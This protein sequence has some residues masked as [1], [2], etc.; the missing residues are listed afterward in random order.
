MSKLNVIP[1]PSYTFG[2][3]IECFGGP[4]LHPAVIAYELRQ[5]GF[6]VRDQYRDE[7]DYGDDRDEDEDDDY[8][9]ERNGDDEDEQIEAAPPPA[10]N[11]GYDS[12]TWIIGGDG[13]IRGQNTMEI[14]SPILKGPEGLREIRRLCNHLRKLGVTVNRSCGLHVHIGIT[15]AEKRFAGDEILMIIKRYRDHQENIDKFLA[16]SRTG[17]RNEFCRPLDQA[18][19]SL[20]QTL[21]M[22]T[23]PVYGPEAPPANWRVMTASQR[24]DWV[25][26]G[27][28]RFYW[29]SD[30]RYH[31]TEEP[32]TMEN[33]V[34]LASCGTHYD[35]V[36]VASLSKYGTIEFRQH[37]G[38]VNGSKITNWI[39][40]L[41][42]HIEVSRMLV[43]EQKQV[44]VAP[45]PKK[46][47]KDTLFLGLSKG[48][49]KHFK[50]QA[51]RL[52]R[53]E[54][55]RASRQAARRAE[56]EAA[57]AARREQQEATRRA[58]EAPIAAPPPPPPMHPPF[59]AIDE[60]ISNIAQSFEWIEVE[61]MDGR[62]RGD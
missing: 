18:V 57:R 38:T 8:E 35:R 26:T 27:A 50:T 23:E 9:N 29:T 12:R 40:F 60:E 24:Q 19:T 5:A 20:E 37:H 54:E 48:V 22:A 47:K 2:C 41:L 3:E 44:A 42:N 31:T 32:V 45:Q 30:Q 21:A 56:R 10:T 15:N 7:S 25:R 43:A 46:I 28:G 6:T 59:E 52:E 58:R 51:K 61:G 14:K 16:R 49:R 4:N 36:S 62:Q 53:R 33:V 34:R 13:S 17:T 55:G 11:N 1:L 39:R